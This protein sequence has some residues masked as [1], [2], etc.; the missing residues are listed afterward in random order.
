MRSA[1]FVK[2]HPR[3]FGAFVTNF[4]CGPDSFVVGYFRD[5]MGTKPSLTL[6]IDSHTADA[7][8]NTRVEAFLDIIERYRKLQISDPP[9]PPF[10]RAYLVSANGNSA[11]VASDGTRW[12]VKD[13]RVKVLMPS[14]GRTTSELS[15]AALRGLGMHAEAVPLPDFQTLML[16]R[17]NTSCK[18]CLPLILTTGS[19]LEHLRER[20]QPDE[21]LLYFMP[22]SNGN[23]RFSQYHVYL[24]GLIEKKRIENVATFTLTSANGYGGMGPVNTVKIYK[25]LVVADVMD[26]IHNALGAL[27]VDAHEAEDAFQREMQSLVQCFERGCK[28][29]Y[30]LL[31]QAALRLSAIPLKQPLAQSKRVLLAGEIFVRKDEFSSQCVVDALAR[32]QIVALR[33]PML[34]WLRFVDYRA[35]YIDPRKLTIADR[36]GLKLRA[37]TFGRIERRIKRILARSGMCSAELVDLEAVMAVGEHFVPKAFGGETILAI[38]RFFK[39]ILRDFHGMISIGPFACLPTRIIQSILTP[40]SKLKG[41]SRVAGFPEGRRLQEHVSLPFLSIEC[42]G[43]PFP[44]I[45]EAQIEAFCLQVERLHGGGSKSG[46]PS[47]KELMVIDSGHETQETSSGGKEF[48]FLSTRG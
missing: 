9:Q 6:E 28:G 32:R 38:G 31:A 13:P 14:M 12:S 48:H 20:R 17:G 40:E 15:C 29:L 22:T 26:D 39:D 23:C 10:R 24:N 41:N 7:G 47:A 3:L 44:Q 2:K 34:E 21:L 18:E 33:A 45:I 1:R 8:V 30:D 37:L 42:D 5:I 27:A 16:G 36:L 43:N 25:S 46:Q 11:M 35:Q 4:S 19:L